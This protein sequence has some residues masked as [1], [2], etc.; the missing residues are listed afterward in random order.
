M[1]LTS[2]GL[3]T[4]MVVIVAFLS[5]FFILGLILE[6]NKEKRRELYELHDEQTNRGLNA[7]TTETAQ[8]A[9]FWLQHGYEQ[10][11]D[12]LPSQS[13]SCWKTDIH[14]VRD[15]LLDLIT[16]KWEKRASGY[17]NNFLNLYHDIFALSFS[18][19]E[20]S[21]RL[22]N[23]CLK[24]YDSYWACTAK[25]TN[26]IQ[27]NF[28]S[29]QIWNHA[30]KTFTESFESEFGKN[31]GYLYWGSNNQTQSVRQQIDQK[32]SA[33]I[34][35]IRPE[36]LRKMSLFDEILNCIAQND[37]MKRCDLLHMQFGN[38]SP[39]EINACYKALLD[40]HK[41]VEFKYGNRIFVTLSD[42]ETQ[43]RNKDSII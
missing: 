16:D 42:K 19:V 33:H 17:L 13:V 21:S 5:F 40:V 2:E 4:A 6:T 35:S 14:E 36:Y 39:K 38:S 43:V 18:D 20:K 24:N 12:V 15:N 25:I 34:E 27:D 37:T 10:A 1:L 41:I 8:D 23:Q 32:L 30:K 29:N 22:K 31:H 3:K 11:K 7:R 26:E 28:I 9:L